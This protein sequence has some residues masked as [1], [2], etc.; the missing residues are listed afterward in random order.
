MPNKCGIPPTRYRWACKDLAMGLTLRSSYIHTTRVSSPVEPIKTYRYGNGV[1]ATTLVHV[2]N[3]RFPPSKRVVRELLSTCCRRYYQTRRLDSDCTSYSNHRPSR[4]KHHSNY[5][6]YLTVP[7]PTR[8]T[9]WLHYPLNTVSS[10][11][12]SLSTASPSHCCSIAILSCSPRRP[13]NGPPCALSMW[14][15][16]SPMASK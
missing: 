1:R 11:S 2:S 14:A 8:P 3:T 10:S 4:S 12:S 13:P 5:P 15:Y 6:G 9:T 16:A 7:R